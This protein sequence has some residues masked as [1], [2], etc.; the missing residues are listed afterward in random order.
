MA[1]SSEAGRSRE[2]ASVVTTGLAINCGPTLVDLRNRVSLLEEIR[3]RRAGVPRQAKQ[4]KAA[5]LQL[6]GTAIQSR[7]GC[8][9]C[10]PSLEPALI[11]MLSKGKSA[12]TWN[13]YAG[14]LR[15]WTAYAATAGTPFLPADPVHFANFLAKESVGEKGYGQT[16]RRVCAIDAISQLAEIPSPSK[17]PGAHW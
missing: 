3:K 17:H 15:G 4:L 2:G 6:L 14:V 9:P 1:G 11:A 16:K 12:S 8:N 13:D 7:S 10:S 5:T